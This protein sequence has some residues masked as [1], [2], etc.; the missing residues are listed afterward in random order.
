MTAPAYSRQ[1]NLPGMIPMSSDKVASW[2]LDATREMIDGNRQVM[3]IARYYDA[4]SDTTMFLAEAWN[5]AQE[6]YPQPDFAF[7]VYDAQVGR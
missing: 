5:A 6:F 3:R 4:K 7:A 1:L 2:V